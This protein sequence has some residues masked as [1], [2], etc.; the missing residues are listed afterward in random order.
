MKNIKPMP[1]KRYIRKLLQ[2]SE[3]FDI[4]LYK[5]PDFQKSHVSFEGMPRKH[6][7]DPKKVV[8]LTDPFSDEKPVLRISISS[9]VF[10]GGNRHHYRRRRSKRAETQA[11]DKEGGRWTKYKPIV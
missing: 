9:I 5:D 6:A 7:S 1:E 2:I 11:V 4:D 3:R 8:L 10:I